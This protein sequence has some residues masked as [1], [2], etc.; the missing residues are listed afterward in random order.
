MAGP[1]RGLLSE[2]PP[3]PYTLSRRLVVAPADVDVLAFAAA[4]DAG[5]AYLPVAG[6]DSAGPLPAGLILP[7]GRDRAAENNGGFAVQK[8]A[9]EIEDFEP[10]R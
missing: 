10:W 1:W 2:L 9:F 3:N 4:S 5:W 7:C 6:H 8:I